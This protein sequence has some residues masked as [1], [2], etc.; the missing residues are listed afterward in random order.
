MVQSLEIGR[1]REPCNPVPL[2]FGMANPH[3][4]EI[5]VRF[6]D[7]DALGHVNNA[8]YASYAELGRLHFLQMLGKHVTD[9]ILATLYIDY[10]RQV[11]YDDRVHIDSWVESLGTSSMT[12]RQAIF[13]NDALAA[14]VKSVVVHFDYAAGKPMPL[15]DDMRA[16]LTS[17]IRPTQG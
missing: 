9:L 2:S 8:A 17:Y 3:R 5:Q 15:T 1:E 7:T 13:A 16:T 11:Q 14:D 10:R 12:V 4:T 6:G